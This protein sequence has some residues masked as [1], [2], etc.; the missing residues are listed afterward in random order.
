MTG[1][2]VVFEVHGQAPFVVAVPRGDRHAAGRV[3][4]HF[5]MM[6]AGRMRTGGCGGFTVTI[7]PD[8]ADCDHDVGTRGNP[9]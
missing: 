7:H 9:A 1:W 3:T 8:G 2:R 6:V 4:D 5:Q